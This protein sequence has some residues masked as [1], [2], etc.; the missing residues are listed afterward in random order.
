MIFIVLITVLAPEWI[1]SLYNDNADYGVTLASE[2]DCTWE[3]A[4]D[5]YSLGH[6]FWAIW[7]TKEPL[8]D[9]NDV[10][11]ISAA[12]RGEPILP[13]IL[14][15]PLGWKRLFEGCWAPVE[16]RFT[17][18]DIID[19]L[20]MIFIS[21]LADGLSS[22]HHDAKISP[23][24]LASPRVS[25]SQK[26]ES[27]TVSLTTW[28][29]RSYSVPIKIPVEAVT[30][31]T[32]PPTSP[33]VSTETSSGTSDEQDEQDE[34]DETMKKSKRYLTMS[35]NDL[36]ERYQEITTSVSSLQQEN[37]RLKKELETQKNQISI[38]TV[39][40]FSEAEKFRSN[41]FAL[42]GPNK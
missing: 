28:T 20:Q 1:K 33:I 39:R 5:I 12:V 36:Y 14:D 32:S 19:C 21:H 2:R 3:K 42:L 4:F 10:Q 16:R 18:N 22:P 30:T 40:F 17:I 15:A 8:E 13:S 9:K 23:R 41:V 7:K 35:Q 24:S 11:I 34:Q 29:S 25:A 27:S 6:I 37:R 31:S 38:E 26:V